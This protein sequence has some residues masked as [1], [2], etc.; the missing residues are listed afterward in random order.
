MKVLGLDPGAARGGYA[1]VA[2]PEEGENKPPISLGSG[3]FCVPRGSNGSKQEPYQQYKLGVIRAWVP[4]AH[5]LLDEF[6]P[7]VVVSEIVP[8]VGGGNFVVATQSQLAAAQ[9]NTVHAVAYDRGYTIKQVGATSVKAKI[10]GAKNASKVK[11][12][13][14]VIEIIPDLAE[15]K[16]DWVKVFEEPDSLAIALTELGYSVG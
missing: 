3:Y 12:R 15:R 1:C 4:W 9:I 6:E 8:V 14:G 2:Q 16:K 7:D 5:Y 13:N 11:V 10:G